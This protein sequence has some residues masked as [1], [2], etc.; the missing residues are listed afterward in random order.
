MSDSFEADLTASLEDRFPEGN[1][2]VSDVVERVKEAQEYEYT[3][4]LDLHDIESVITGIENW[5]QDQGITAGWNRW[6]TVGV[7]DTDTSH[8]KV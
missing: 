6:I 8:L 3:S 5:S 2:E 1:D 7:P 4:H